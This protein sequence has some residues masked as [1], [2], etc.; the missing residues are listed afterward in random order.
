MLS[1]CGEGTVDPQG[2]V[3]ES[4]LGEASADTLAV[5]SVSPTED[6]ADA[7]GGANKL[8][9]P[10]MNAVRSARQYLEMSGF[11]RAGLIQQLSS[12]AGDGYSVEDATVAVDSLG[13]DWNQNAA[14]SA[15]EYLEMMGFSCQGLVEQLSSDFG[16][17]Y[18]SEQAQYGARQAGVC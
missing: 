13:A 18:T 6:A 9:F 2:S 12:D 8:T 7:G 14:R 1:S 15:Q 4:G 10:Q 5:G 3:A 17:R 16:D 11:S